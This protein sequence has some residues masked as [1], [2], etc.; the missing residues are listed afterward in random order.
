[1]LP[2]PTTIR[3]SP[4]AAATIRTSSLPCSPD[5]SLTRRRCRCEEI[6]DSV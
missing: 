4:E 3:M 1:M 6:F 5:L 2:I